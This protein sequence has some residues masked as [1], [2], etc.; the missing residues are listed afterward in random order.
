MEQRLSLEN[1]IIN[2]ATVLGAGRS[3]LAAAKV[4]VKQGVKVFLSDEKEPSDEAKTELKTL[5]ISFEIN[6]HTPRALESDVLIVSPGMDW[7]HPFLKQ[8]RNYQKPI[9]GELELGF[10]LCPTQRIIAITG[11]NGK[12]TTTRLITALLK[13]Q[14]HSVVAGSNLGI[15]FCDL[16]SDIKPDTWVVLEVSSFQLESVETFHPYIGVWL[17]LTPDH[18]DR[19]QSMEHYRSLKQRL[20]EHQTKDDHA[21][22]DKSI[23]LDKTYLSQRH[24]IDIG[25]I[26]LGIPKHQKQNLSAAL[27]TA[28]LANPDCRLEDIDWKAV[29]KRPHCLEYVDTVNNIAFYNDSKATNPEATIAALES[30]KE[31]GPVCV[32]LGGE[33]KNTDPSN[34]VHYISNHS[35]VAQAIT[36]GPFAAYWNNAL[37]QAGFTTFDSV[38][39]ID[40][41]LSK[42]NPQIRTCVLSPAGSSF[43]QFSNYQAR[44]NAFKQAVKVLSNAT[45]SSI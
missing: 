18:L 35:H 15:P 41:S 11:T 36:F 32:L 7:Q 27:K 38:P 8:A 30:F 45:P 43:D 13:S 12:S 40:E 22:L 20:F 39:H 44:G 24:F 6:G 4:L 3:G 19:H 2:T 37:Q 26:R 42:L 17:N 14:K 23:A 1:S 34:L 9:W 21:V 10:R 33:S 5:G 28:Q 31:Q 16:L 25:E 29:V